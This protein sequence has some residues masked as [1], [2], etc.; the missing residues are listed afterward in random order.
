MA[1]LLFLYKLI[2]RIKRNYNYWHHFNKIEKL[3]KMGLKIGSNVT[4]M[5]T[6]EIDDSY[7]Y[8]ISIGDNSS[9]SKYVQLIA[10]DQAASKFTEKNYERLGKIEIKENCYIG[11]SAIILPGVTIGPNVLV[12]AGSVVNKDIPP[13]SCVAGVPARVYAKF[14]DFI[15]KHKKFA[16]EGK[17]FD[18]K[19]T[20]HSLNEETIKKVREAV[21]DGHTYISGF[22]GKGIESFPYIVN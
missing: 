4:I 8:L 11:Q 7:P 9:I 16:D 21:K 15:E 22:Q 13:N 20:S 19:D 18:S 5:P 10:H 1:K 2:D 3:R 14:D 12:S 17:V 6:A